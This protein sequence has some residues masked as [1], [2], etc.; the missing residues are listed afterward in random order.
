M[1]TAIEDEFHD[2]ILQKFGATHLV[3]AEIKQMDLAMLAAE[4]AQLLPR[5][6]TIEWHQL[7]GV[8]PAN[9]Y[10][11]Q[12]SQQHAENQFMAQYNELKK[13]LDEETS[14]QA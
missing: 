4:K 9:I 11:G 8:Q 10:I 6:H 7:K 5:E 1:T 13:I 14:W 12:W 2:V 3:A